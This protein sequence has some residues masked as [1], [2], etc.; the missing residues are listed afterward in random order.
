MHTFGEL[1]EPLL[2]EDSS[3]ADTVSG[4]VFKSASQFG[5]MGIPGL[6]LSA[7][8]AAD[9]DAHRP[10]LLPGKSDIENPALD[11]GERGG[12]GGGGGNAA[13]VCAPVRCLHP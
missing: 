4:P 6:G 12:G 5:P 9:A 8:D 3:E 7:P 10:A 11:A 1:S 13:E 2:P